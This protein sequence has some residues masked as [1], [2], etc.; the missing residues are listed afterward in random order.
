[1]ILTCPAC[2]TRYLVPDTAVGPSGR[3]VRCAKCRHSWFMPQPTAAAPPTAVELPLEPPSPP[4]RESVA[5]PAPPP[6]AASDPLP[7]RDSDNDGGSYERGVDAFAHEPPFRARRNLS[8][9]W[10]M[11]AAAAAIL[12]LG[13]I[14][15]IEYFG[16]PSFL[17]KYGFPVGV[18]ESPLLLE[19]PLKPY[20]GTL[21]NG[22]EVFSITGKIVNPT[23]DSQ[24]VPD[25]LAELRDA[26]GR[27]VYSWT[28]NPP[29]RTVA[30]KDAIE[31][32]S[33]EVNVPKGARA[34][35]L[36]FS[37]E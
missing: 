13:S 16:T 10:T 26:Q 23:S 11:A 12:M 30:P 31:F 15:A 7:P 24:R 36:R 33:A 35:N 5:F 21:N 37:G 19:I 6:I 2:S 28:I 3:Q 4:P 25:I 32:N 29:K 17:A 18:A 20:R 22:N 1:M 8:R 14:G 34:L 9:R 27:I